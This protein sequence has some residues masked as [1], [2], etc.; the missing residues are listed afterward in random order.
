ML[1]FSLLLLC[2]TKLHILLKM[3]QNPSTPAVSGSDLDGGSSS[4]TIEVLFFGSARDAVGNVSAITLGL[5]VGSDTAT[6]R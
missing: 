1:L 5:P 3:M 6:L 4:F 2:V